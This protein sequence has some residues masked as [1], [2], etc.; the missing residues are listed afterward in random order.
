MNH[1]AQASVSGGWVFAGGGAALQARLE[2]DENADLLGGED[3]LDGTDQDTVANAE[4]L[5]DVR[6]GDQGDES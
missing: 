6:G 4:Q 3:I 5:Q 1:A 2:G